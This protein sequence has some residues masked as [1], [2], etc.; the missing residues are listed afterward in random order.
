ME[1]EGDGGW[2]THY[3]QHMGLDFIV[4]DMAVFFEQLACCLRELRD[5]GVGDVVGDVFI[6]AALGHGGDVFSSGHS[7]REDIWSGID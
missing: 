7:E 4:W 1:W 2:D 5:V 6:G 3:L